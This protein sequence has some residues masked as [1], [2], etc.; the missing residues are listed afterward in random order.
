MQDRFID[1][2]PRLHNLLQFYFDVHKQDFHSTPLALVHSR[3]FAKS[4]ILKLIQAVF[5]PLPLLDGYT[6]DDVKSK[7]R[8]CVKGPAL[9][10]F[11]MHPVFLLDM[12]LASSIASM[13]SLIASA[14]KDAGLENKTV[15]ALENH[16]VSLAVFLREGVRALNERFC[17]ETGKV[18]K[19]I[20]LIDEFDKPFRA[21]NPDVKLLEAC[22][23]VYGLCKDKDTGI[24]LF[25]VAGLTRMAGS[26]LSDMNT[27]NR[28]ADISFQRTHHGLG[29]ISQS[30]LLAWGPTRNELDVKA[31]E[32]FGKS[33]ENLV[34]E[35][36]LEW[37]GFCFAID[38]PSET[39][40]PLF[41]PVDVWQLIQD[42]QENHAYRSSV[43]LE[44]MYS[45]F[46]FTNFRDQFA[47]KPFFLQ[48][49]KHLGG[50]WMKQS[51]LRMPFSRD[52]YQSL[53]NPHVVKR[54]LLELGILAVKDVTKDGMVLLAPPNKGVMEAGFGLLLNK[55]GFNT[56]PSTAE[57]QELL[58]EAEF[59]R[60][61]DQAAMEVS[62]M[63]SASDWIREYA[64][65]DALYL[66]L[67]QRLPKLS[68]AEY[69]LEAEYSSSGR[70]DIHG[71]QTAG[72]YL[73]C[74]I[75]LNSRFSTQGIAD[76]HDR[77]L[78]AANNQ[79]HS[80]LMPA[81][82]FSRAL[83]VAV[84]GVW[85][86]VGSRQEGRANPRY[87]LDVKCTF[88]ERHLAKG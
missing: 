70:V 31:R 28:Y 16:T 75:K 64:F 76:C 73:N 3:R 4:T 56:M 20:V 37:N 25:I 87:K 80:R 23:E 61:I 50:G 49:S 6:F 78:E 79:L 41:S 18:T 66:L 19:T 12:Q 32:V 57:V 71:H 52:D 33:I 21:L 81:G 24:S 88:E 26:G 5:S 42:L 10:A 46:E 62:S 83:N 77:Q 29:G 22:G 9:L 15:D 35:L 1:K 45:E 40:D 58:S 85:T 44:T 14:L 65:Q 27:L 60:V 84:S 13:R 51:D 38:A 67:L 47:A 74:E 7:I 8:A 68:E 82:D 2:T 11:G 17:A 55:T 72:C 86:R 54:V 59:K 43:W 69:E 34:A 53:K 30:E 48:L 63:F 39:A 36:A